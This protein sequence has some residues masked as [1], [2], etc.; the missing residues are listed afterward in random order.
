MAYL[1]ANFKLMGLL[2]RE[3]CWYLHLYIQAEPFKM[4]YYLMKEDIELDIYSYH[5]IE[6]KN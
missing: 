3:N 1:I 6:S 2:F 4:S 5:E